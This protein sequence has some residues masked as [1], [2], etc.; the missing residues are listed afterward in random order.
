[1]NVLW[2]AVVTLLSLLAWGGQA[3]S[4]LSPKTAVKW[5]VMEAEDDVEPAFWADVRGEAMWDTFTLWTM[6]IAGVLLT[7]DNSAWPYF[8]LVGGGMYLYFG[9][10][11]IASRAAMLRLGL[12]I[13]APGNVRLGFAFSA[14]W[15]VMALVTII[16]AIVT[17]DG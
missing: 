10:R 9:G 14:I 7:A 12:R 3:V 11:G 6:V 4:W 5:K 15:A 2:G 1:M 17:L 13:G 8:G 16:A